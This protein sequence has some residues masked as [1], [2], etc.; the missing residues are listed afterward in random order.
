MITAKEI[1]KLRS[2]T[3]LPVMEIK[4]ALTEAKGDKEEAVK[5]LRQRGLSKI[6]KRADRETKSGLIENYVHDG[7]IGVLVEVLTESDFVAKNSDFVEFVHNLALHIAAANPKYISHNN[8][9]TKEIEEEKQ[10]LLDQVEKSGKSVEITKKIIE[11]KMKNYY[12]EICL[13]NQPYIK[14]QEK[15]VG[16]LLAD[17]VAKIGEKIVISRFVRFELG[18]K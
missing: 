2:K 11:G 9:P 16:D 12:A 14:D 10:N 18:E 1:A 5:I 3:G 13:L 7:K 15:T 6:A 8:I 17:L 4:S